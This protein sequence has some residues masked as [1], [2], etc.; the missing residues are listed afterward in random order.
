MRSVFQDLRY[1]TRTLLKRPGFTFVAVLTLALGIGANTAIFSIVNTVMLRPLPYQSPEQL[2]RV[3]GAN[4]GKG[5]QL[6]SFSPQDFYDW[7]DQNTVFEALAACDKWSLNLTGD[8]EPERI[9][10]YAVSAGFFNILRAQPQL[11]RT[12]LPREDTLGNEY[13]AVLSNRL[14]Q[15]RFNSDP[16]IVGRQ[17]TL[18]GEKFT[19]IGVMPS[20]FKFPPL[21]RAG[22]VEP[23]L[24]VPFAPELSDW[25][26]SSRSVDGAIARLKAGVTL[27]QAETELKAIA[28]RLEQQYPETNSSQSVSVVSLHESI[29]GSTRTSLL[30]FLVAVGFVLLIA[31]AN[32]ANL[33]LARAATRRKE[34]AIRTALGAGRS[35]IIR[36]LLT[37][38]VLLSLAGGA[39]GLLLSLWATDFLVNLASDAIRYVGEVQM[40]ARVL[41]FTLLASLLTGIIFG[42][43]PAL[44]VSNPDLNE[45]LKEG[46]RGSGQGAGRQRVR[47]LLIISEVAL[48]LVLLVGAGLLVK[49][50]LRLQEVS[51]GFSP[52]NLLTMYVSL[53]GTKYPEDEQHVT[54]FN[55][56]LEGVRALPGVESA[57]VV[58]VLPISENYD[59]FGIEIESR[60]PVPLGEAPEAD[61]YRISPDYFRTMNI[62]LQAGRAFSERDRADAPPVVIINE[63]MARRYWPD[64]SAV[65][66]RL[67]GVAAGYP[68][69]EVVGVVG[70]VKQYGLDTANTL[71]MYLPQAQSP[72]QHMTLVV[73]TGGNPNSYF[74]TVREKVWEVDKEQPVY[75][76]RTM[77]QLL[78]TSVAQRR[79][80]MLLLAIFAGVALVL[81]AVGL[82]GVM[83]YAVTQRTHEIG[84]RMALGARAGD[85]LKMVIGQGMLLALIGVG[86]GLAVALAVTRVMATLLYGVST[87]DPAVFVGIPLL[88]SAVAFAACYIPARRATKVDPMVALRYE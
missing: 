52:E 27:D 83:S 70:D 16:G 1:G 78:S 8:G 34:I 75:N 48:S 73:R 50:F 58:S 79:F 25:P 47:S 26:R 5:R 60:P 19:V 21:A 76:I 49:S 20:T 24:W 37:E 66:K 3:G 33:L 2:V 18:S 81:A 53:P 44:Q 68:W 63:T 22:L 38:S 87:T 35:R 15:R 57:S 12:F 17:V 74:T 67:K 69:L 64:G 40:D 31:C 10:A 29:V 42:L 41:A 13:V 85:V 86:V 72:T 39:L 30:V 7:R 54:F 55:R 32:V 65:G 6:T 59:R 51:P 61:R 28:G 9:E 43:M 84:I 82:Y 11:G 80:N 4:Y 14:W 36:Q 46:G 56:V 88:L 23:E 62:P 45:T 77:E 71:Q